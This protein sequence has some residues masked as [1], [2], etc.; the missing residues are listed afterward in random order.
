M[1]SDHEIWVPRGMIS[2]PQAVENDM[3]IDSLHLIFTF[4]L[5]SVT[6]VMEIF[7]FVVFH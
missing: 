2:L 7:P 1:V 6:L 3:K 5:N 4:Y